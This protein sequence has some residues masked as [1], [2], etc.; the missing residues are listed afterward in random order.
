MAERTRAELEAE[1]AAAREALDRARAEQLRIE[2]ALGRFVPHQFLDLL[3]KSHVG[4]LALGDAVEAKLTILFLDVR[5]FT[6][7][8]E[9]LSPRGVFQLVNALFGAL[10]PE[11]ERHGGFVDKYIGDAIMALFPGGASD[12]IAAAV[13]MLR[14]LARFD[15]ARAPTPPVQVGIGLNT[16]VAMLGTVGDA[17]RMETTVLS[18]AVNLA[19]RIEELTKR[20]GTP[21]LISEATLYATG[22]L[23]GPHMRF[24]DRIRVKGKTQP[25]S[26]YEVFEADP[27]ALREAKARGRARFEEAAAWYHLVRIDRA[28]PLLEECLCDA[29][30]DAPA[31]AYLERCHAYLRDGRHEGTGEL[32]GTVEWRD[33]FTVGWA[34]IDE[35]HRALLAAMNRLAPSLGRRDHDGVREVLA[36]LEGYVREHF[37]TE[38]ALMTAHRYPFTAQHRR[39]HQSFVEHL[40]RLRSEIESG[41][42][43]YPFLVFL[44]QIFLI[45]WFANHSTSIDR[46][47][48]RYLRRVGAPER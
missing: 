46:H 37:G 18:D 21:L 19:S 24:V 20:Y 12:A 6:P 44:T 4:E 3:G 27:P 43:E 13:A 45:D 32:A 39:E 47:L 14:A 23:P 5:G 1:L 7:M 42:H 34:V 33:E 22:A 38:E 9:G 8:C 11:V 10:V 29:P 2:R 40:A 36:F 35:Q 25:Q 17:E 31:R 48:A 41:R 15:D 28:L 30:D 16:G 26:V